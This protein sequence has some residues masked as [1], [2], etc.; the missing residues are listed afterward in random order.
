LSPRAGFEVGKDEI[1]AERDQPLAE[2]KVGPLAS[3]TSSL[4]LSTYFTTGSSKLRV[5]LDEINICLR[6]RRGVVVIDHINTE[7]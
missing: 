4:W 5:S 7:A 1:G 3:V 2:D 6:V